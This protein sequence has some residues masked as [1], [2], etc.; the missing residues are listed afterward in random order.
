MF[1]FEPQYLQI[2]A[3]NHQVTLVNCNPQDA[4]NTT[5]NY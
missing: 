2:N 5:L 1:S 4:Y 3:M